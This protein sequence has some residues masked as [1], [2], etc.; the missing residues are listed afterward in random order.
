MS[1]NNYKANIDEND[2]VI[3][4]LGF[5]NMH[6]VKVVKGQ[7]FQTKFGALRL[8]NLVGKPYG[9][10]V[11]C[12]KGYLYV[13]YP[14]PELWT[15]NLPHRTQIL[16]ST[17]ISLVTL[18]LDLKPG[19]IV[20]ESGTGSGSLSHAIIRTIAPEGHLYTFE[21]H[22]QR[23]EKAKEEFIEHGVADNVTVTHKDVCQDGFGLDHVADS[24][25]LD[26]PRPWEALQSAKQALKKEGGRLCSFSPC[27]EQVQ[28]TCELLQEL[29]FEDI[30]TMECLVKNYDV[31][32]V[33]LP[34][35]DLGSEVIG[36]IT[37]DSKS[38]ENKT[39]YIETDIKQES[40][41][42]EDN[43]AAAK[44]NKLRTDFDLIGKKEQQSFYFKTGVFP[45]NMPGHTGY[46]TFCTLYP[47]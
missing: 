38:I 39:A 20:V 37:A 42:T 41:E 15:Q 32:T 35:A 12:P 25:F 13:L 31:R 33:N 21:F 22:E 36:N 8:S 23:A 27:I 4:Y 29:G 44:K 18:Q 14:T 10:K 11:E 47:L 5:E 17:D 40:M 2:T 45:Q 19:S 28:K 16:Y 46:L 24:V 3:L 26:L 9:S 34:I 7:T 1:F 6:A 30:T 43:T